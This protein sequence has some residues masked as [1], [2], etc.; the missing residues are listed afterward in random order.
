MNLK[1]QKPTMLGIGIMVLFEESCLHQQ[2]VSRLDVPAAM[3]RQWL[4][5]AALGARAGHGQQ[6]EHQGAEGG[7][8]R[9]VTD[10][11]VSSSSPASPAWG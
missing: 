11:H 2:T 8:Q 3:I 1:C 7:C 10:F 6:A 4:R 9:P 5:A